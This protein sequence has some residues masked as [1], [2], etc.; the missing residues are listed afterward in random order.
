MLNRPG[1]LVGGYRLLS[2]FVFGYSISAVITK[3]LKTSQEVMM[4][5]MNRSAMEWHLKCCDQSQ[6]LDI[7]LYTY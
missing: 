3:W 7:A 6:G 1:E 2:I 4:G 5:Q